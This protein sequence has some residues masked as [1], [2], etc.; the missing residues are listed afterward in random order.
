MEIVDSQTHRHT[1]KIL[2]LVW[3]WLKGWVARES[4]GTNRQARIL[5][6]YV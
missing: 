3:F 5:S 1:D 2:L 4:A 6:L